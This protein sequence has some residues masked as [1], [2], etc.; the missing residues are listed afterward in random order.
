MANYR[1]LRGD[2]AVSA[3]VK[4]TDEDKL[5]LCRMIFGE[6]GSANDL[7]AAKEYPALLWAMV[8]RFLLHP[9]RDI[10]V[11]DP[12]NG[13]PTNFCRML[14]AFSQPIN[15]R[16]MAGGDLAITHSMDESTSAARLARRAKICKMSLE[17]IPDGIQESVEDF[18]D[19]VL[20]VPV[21]VAA[22]SRPRIS[23]WASYKNVE[24]KFPGGVRIGG[25]YFFEDRNMTAGHVVVDYLG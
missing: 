11:A 25:K 10:W 1:I 9:R 22:I 19:G 15:P 6:R 17:S 16:W 14:R 2:L 8:N 20:P 4:F 21:V 7:T 23:N 13:Y 24:Q 5:W 12:D 18:C 3:S